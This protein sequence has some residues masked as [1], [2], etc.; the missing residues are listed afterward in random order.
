MPLLHTAQLRQE[1]EQPRAP[2]VTPPPL[3]K[4]SP[5]W[6]HRRV[7]VAFFALAALAWFGSDIVLTV[8]VGFFMCNFW[9]NFAKGS[10]DP[11][12]SIETFGSAGPGAGAD[13]VRKTQALSIAERI[14][15]C[16]A[17]FRWD[18]PG[19]E[20]WKC[21]GDGP[22]PT[23]ETNCWSE[24]DERNFFLRG[25]QYLQDR[26]KVQAAAPM[27]TLLRVSAFTSEEKHQHVA[28]MPFVKRFLEAHPDQ[29]FVI[30]VRYMYVDG[31]VIHVVAIFVRSLPRG[32]RPHQDRLFDRFFARPRSAWEREELNRFRL[33]RFK[34]ICDFRVAP[35]M[36]GAFIESLGGTRPVILGNTIGAQFFDGPNYVEVL[37]D[38][39][40]NQLG[41]MVVGSVVGYCR[42]M[43]ID[44]LFVLEGQ[45]EEELPEQPLGLMRVNYVDVRAVARP[46]PASFE[47]CSAD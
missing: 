9:Y 2:A 44:E 4:A 42:G 41:K 30:I 45:T 40:G 29:Q 13:P 34:Y 5:K 46:F 36:V 31:K 20:P 33:K 14:A 25:A 26:V 8:F 28:Q 22:D 27:C 35:R 19:A 11:V 47:D 43:M 17:A 18:V 10:D 39:T 12:A 6:R 23:D 38:T 24:A 7:A 1:V 15:H 37:V 32:E 3:K 16:R 21:I